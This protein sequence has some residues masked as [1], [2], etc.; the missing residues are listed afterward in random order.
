MGVNNRFIP[1][2][3]NK[4][5][6]YKKYIELFENQFIICL[7]LLG[8]IMLLKAINVPTANAVTNATKA[9]LNYNMDY[10]NAKKG[11]KLVMGKI[12][13]IKNNVI[14][15]FSNNE[16]STNTSTNASVKISDRMIPPINGAITSGFGSRIDPISY[17]ETNHDGIDIDAPVGENVKAVLD[18]EVMFTDANNKDLGK[19]IVLR[20][21]ND[22]RTVY[23]HLSEIDVKNGDQVKQG[24]IIGKTGDTGRVTAPHL[25]FEVWENGKPVNPL[26]KVSIEE[27]PSG[28][29]K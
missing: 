26:T 21:A 20:H 19:V 2:H 6:S 7:V 3:G 13:H 28:G 23:A 4:H 9:V 25:H 22:V 29:S 16:E 18:G 15:V 11:L 14:K 24:D 10:E 27:K 17:K 5:K 12:P 8:V 1:Y